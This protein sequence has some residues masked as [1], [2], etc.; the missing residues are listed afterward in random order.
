MAKERL[1]IRVFEGGHNIEPEVIERRYNRGINNL[2]NIYLP[3]V[4]ECLI[5]DNTNLDYELFAVKTDANSF[6]IINQ[7]KWK[8]L[9]RKN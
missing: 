6:Y 8:T 9:T 4:N 2:I 5:F 1:R 3:L 7:E